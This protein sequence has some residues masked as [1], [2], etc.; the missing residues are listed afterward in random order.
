[1]A[2]YS[3]LS[4]DEKSV[5]IVEMSGTGAFQPCRLTPFDG[6]SPG[7]PVGP[8]GT[9]TSA[10]WSPDGTWM[11]FSAYVGGASHLWRQRFPDGLPEQIT[12]GA[13][14]EEG[15]AVAPDGRS[16]VARRREFVSMGGFSFA[17]LSISI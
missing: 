7:H 11:Y 9:C 13:T 16:L 17:H 1:M 10:G 5:L 3:Y 2:H 15:L 6:S 4:P 14:E 8:H 12:F